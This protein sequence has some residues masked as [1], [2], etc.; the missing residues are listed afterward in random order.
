[1]KEGFLI[2]ILS[3]WWVRLAATQGTFDSV[4]NNAIQVALRGEAGG[5][6]QQ[7]AF[8]LPSGSSPLQAVGSI[9]VSKY[10]EHDM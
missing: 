7:A 1:M 10:I 8:G 9:P 5:V 4:V 3:I 6:P 2:S